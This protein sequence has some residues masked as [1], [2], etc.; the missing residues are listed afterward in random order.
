MLGVTAGI[1][2]VVQGREV[3]SSRYKVEVSS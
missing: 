1:G 2:K 3:V